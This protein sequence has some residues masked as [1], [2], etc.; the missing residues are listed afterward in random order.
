MGGNTSALFSTGH[1]VK[2]DDLEAMWNS[3]CKNRLVTPY[4]QPIENRKEI[5]ACKGHEHREGK[6]VYFPEEGMI[7][8]PVWIYWAANKSKPSDVVINFYRKDIAVASINQFELKAL[9]EPTGKGDR[10]TAF[11]KVNDEGV[12]LYTAQI[13]IGPNNRVFTQF[14]TV[15]KQQAFV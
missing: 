3:F 12:R 10:F 2:S 11:L 5:E 9:C 4:L 15:K 13:R 6:A 14:G 7:A 1:S 8:Q